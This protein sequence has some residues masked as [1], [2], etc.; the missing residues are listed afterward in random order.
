MAELYEL[1]TAGVDRGPVPLQSGA[2]TEELSRI[3]TMIR[4]GLPE[5]TGVSFSFDGKL[6]VHIDV[7]KREEVTIVE[8]VL[9]S[10]EPGLLCGLSRGRTPGHP[11][12]HRITATVCA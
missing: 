8:M 2:I 11:F 4:S 10:L 7:R 6:Q 1:A 9:P 3:T 5:V 12:H